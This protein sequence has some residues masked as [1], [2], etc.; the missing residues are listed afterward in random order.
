MFVHIV[1]HPQHKR[2]RCTT[3]VIVHATSSALLAYLQFLIFKCITTCMIVL[4]PT[5]I[6]LVVLQMCEHYVAINE[7]KINILISIVVTRSSGIPILNK[8]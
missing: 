1:L 8:D 4:M 3:A 2:Q 7:L 5:F 6:Y